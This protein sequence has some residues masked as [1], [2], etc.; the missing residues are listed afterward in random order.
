MEIKFDHL[1]KSDDVREAMQ[2]KLSVLRERFAIVGFNP[3]TNDLLLALYN[4]KHGIEHFD[5]HGNK[6]EKNSTFEEGDAL[7][8]RFSSHLDLRLKKEDGAMTLSI[9]GFKYSP[10]D[11][12]DKGENAKFAL[13]ERALAAM[14]LVESAKAAGI[15]PI[16]FGKT[17]DPVERYLLAL[18]CEKQGV[19]HV[20]TENIS[21]DILPNAFSFN[22]ETED[23][24]AEKFSNRADQYY[25][26]MCKGPRSEILKNG[27]DENSPP[28]EIST[29]K[30]VGETIPK[31]PSD[32]K[33]EAARKKF[34]EGLQALKAKA[35]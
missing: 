1:F 10:Y 28:Y 4:R 21:Q 30:T 5:K 31:V 19:K 25:Q 18:A 15:E 24:K 26:F 8:A 7:S 17:K 23:K 16:S 2:N 34:A 33:K 6:K 3:L 13:K 11:L 29:A 22:P 9:E 32:D 35:A 14:L 27:D 12:A 20:E